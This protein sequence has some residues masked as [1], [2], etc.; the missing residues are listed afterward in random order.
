MSMGDNESW[1]PWISFCFCKKRRS[2]H[3]RFFPGIFQAFA[4]RRLQPSGYEKQ[5]P[6]GRK[7]SLQFLLFL[8]ADKFFYQRVD[9]I[10]FFVLHPV[11][12]ILKFDQSPL[13]AE[14]HAFLR[15]L[16]DD[17]DIVDTP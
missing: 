14:G 10:G 3:G 5:K 12:G 17:G 13:I 8:T 7:R 16:G 6:E 2:I 15:L 11:G 1:R 9:F 4:G